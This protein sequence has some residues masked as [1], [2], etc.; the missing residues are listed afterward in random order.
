MCVLA[1]L[2]LEEFECRF[3]ADITCG[4]LVSYLYSPS[5]VQI[6]GSV[7]GHVVSRGTAATR[8]SEPATAVKT[9]T[10]KVRPPQ[11]PAL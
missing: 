10:W 7:R 5:S 9:R 3:A 4:L 1:H 8:V 2:C 6:L 11:F